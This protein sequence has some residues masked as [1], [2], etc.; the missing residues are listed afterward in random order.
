VK[1]TEQPVGVLPPLG[2]EKEQGKPSRKRTRRGRHRQKPPGVYEFQWPRN[3]ETAQRGAH[4]VECE[5]EDSIGLNRMELR[6]ELQ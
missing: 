1:P 6:L 4:A 5:A 3:I 2:E